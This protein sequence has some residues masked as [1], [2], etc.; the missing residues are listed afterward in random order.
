MSQADT[1]SP[2]EQC[3]GSTL[4]NAPALAKALMVFAG[5]LHQHSTLPRRLIEL[6]RLRIAFHNQCRSCMAIRYQSAV[7][8]GLTE[9]LV[10][11][12]EK[13]QDAPD[14][15]AAEKAAI[16]YADLS[17]TNHFAIDEHTFA[18]L[19]RHYS[20]AEI[21]E[22]GLFIAYFIGFGRLAAAWDMVEELPRD[23]QDKSRR[24]APWTH[25][26][27]RQR[28][29]R[30]A[31]PSHPGAPPPRAPPG[32]GGGGPHPPPPAA[33]A[34]NFTRTEA[35]IMAGYAQIERS[36]RPWPSLPDRR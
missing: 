25:G 20:E 7:D 33:V 32:G 15:S 24:A 1:G 36:P 35:M 30:R 19:R 29:R 9:G 31:T 11:S 14:L 34:Q 13:P 8:A 23:L 16:E 3:M 4:A 6:L 17:A 5:S 21:V 22:L 2:L 28:C 10:C 27:V 12:L 18:A 26:S